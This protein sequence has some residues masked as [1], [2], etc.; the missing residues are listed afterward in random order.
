DKDYDNRAIDYMD[1]ATFYF[2]MLKFCREKPA[3]V[4]SGNHD[5]YYKP[6]GISPRF[7]TVRAN[8][9]IPA[10]HNLTIYEAI[11]IY[12]STYAEN[13]G[14]SF[15]PDRFKWFYSV[16]TPFS[17]F[18]ASLPKQSIVGLGWGD[19]EDKIGITEHQEKWYGH[20]PRA[21][22]SISVTQNKL[23][24][25]AKKKVKGKGKIILFSHFT[26]VS[27][28]SDEPMSRQ[29]PGL[30]ELIDT[31]GSVAYGN[32]DSGAFEGM[33]DPIF[34][35]LSKHKDQDVR[36]ILTGHSHRKG[37]YSISKPDAQ[38]GKKKGKVF[39]ETVEIDTKKSSINTRIFDFEIFEKANLVNINP[40][41]IV[42]DCAGP[43]PRYNKKGELAGWG[44]DKASGTKLIFTED[45][46][47]EEV[48]I[49]QVG[50]L[51]RF[52]VAVDYIDLVGDQKVIEEFVG[53]EIGNDMVFNLSLNSAVSA[54]ARVEKIILYAKYKNNGADSWE[55]I[56]LSRMDGGDQ[57]WKISGQ[58]IIYTFK[59]FAEDRNFVDN[60]NTLKGEWKTK[61]E[62]RHGKPSVFRGNEYVDKGAKI[63]V[64]RV[65][66]N[67]EK[68]FIAMKF[69]GID[70]FFKDFKKK[71]NFN[72]AW[73]FPIS[74]AVTN[75]GGKGSKY[76]LYRDR[77]PL[78]NVTE[79]PDF[80]WYKQQFK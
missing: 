56:I 44:S 14:G 20:L 43:I 23:L 29:E 17:D 51:P 71:Y 76:N 67:L 28:L 79:F 22:K 75:P 59:M 25:S 54:W 7:A 39:G 80:A 5:V 31:Q 38:Y 61:W 18:A 49:E 69:E 21:D 68:K 4:V 6:Y 34:E 62:S 30:M 47:I 15:D 1:F 73:C 27:Y 50:N 10:D 52:I 33:R 19:D 13:G 11:L 60:W 74:S 35:D 24:D 36:C 78:N 12:G 32:F 53:D 45:G 42:S 40:A 63:R 72:S 46:E 66:S 70:F 41:I 26:F 58:D 57:V 2:L 3:F 37:L 55:R 9:G 16:L 77:S 65:D 48:K 64:E 8:S